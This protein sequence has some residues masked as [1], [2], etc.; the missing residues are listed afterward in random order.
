MV[1]GFRLLERGEIEEI[2][3]STLRLLERTGVEVRNEEALSLLEEN[4]CEVEERRVRIP[5]ELVEE[6]LRRAPSKIELHSRDGERRLLI[7]GDNVVYNPG[8]A[9]IYF[10]DYET[11]EIRRGTSRDLE[12]LVR[13]A[14]ALRHIEAQSTAIVPSDVPEEVA[15]LYRLYIVLRNSDKPI[16]TG[17]FSK[18]GLIDMA[19]ML[20][21]A[22]GGAEKLGRRPRAIFDCCPTSPLIWGDVTAQNLLDCAD[23]GIPAE[24]IPAPQI[25]ATSPATLAGTLLQSNAEILS[26]VVITQLRR[27]GAPVIYGG[28]PTLFDMRYVTARLGAIEAVMT[29]CA[30][31]EIGRHYGLPTHGYL[32]LSDSKVVDGQSC[33]ESAIGII[34]AALTGVN[35]VS[36]PGMLVEENCQSLE[37]LVIDDELCG[38]A[39]R[40]LE[41][42]EVEGETLALEVIERVGPG[43]HFLAERHTMKH[44]RRERYI[45][46]D[47]VCRLTVDA[48]RKAGSKDILTRARER[49]E[50]LL[51]EHQPKPMPEERAQALEEVLDSIFQRYG[52]KRP[53]V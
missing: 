40:L 32:G 21:A 12:R 38:M 2:H 50:K 29:A 18:Q 16:I 36:G 49:V 7:G 27:A 3:S 37:K 8:S 30:G 23:R 46:S 9:A 44:F 25:G 34:M 42:I 26:G 47:V 45:P 11:G 43:G 24:I 14:D 28:S 39:Y 15:D 53:E 35:V 17:A 48:W 19:E 20:N 4:G 31:A 13:L 6:C 41:G 5:G 51:R 10:L 52:L 1:R 33:F 22:V